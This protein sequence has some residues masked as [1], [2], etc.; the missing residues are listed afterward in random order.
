[1]K[2]NGMSIRKIANLLPNPR[3]GKLFHPTQIARML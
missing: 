2:T 1:M 3:T